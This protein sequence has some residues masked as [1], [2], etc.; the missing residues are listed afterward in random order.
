MYGAAMDTEGKVSVLAS[1]TMYCYPRWFL[2]YVLSVII[3]VSL[4]IVPIQFAGPNAATMGADVIA[5]PTNTVV[6]DKQ[7]MYWMAGKVGCLYLFTP[8]KPNRHPY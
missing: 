5:G 8:T 4:F 7:H 1:R 6:I 2:A 3:L